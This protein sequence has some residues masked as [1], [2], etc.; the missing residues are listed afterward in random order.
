VRGSERAEEYV[1]LETTFTRDFESRREA[2]SRLA[3]AHRTG[4]GVEDAGAAF[5]A[6]QSAFRATRDRAAGLVKEITGDQTYTDANYVFPTFITTML[7]VGLTGLMIAAIFAAVMSSVSSE[8]NALSTA[9]VMD[10]YR[11]H[12]RTTDTTEHYLRVSK[13]TTGAWGVFACV[14]ATQAATIGT[15][16]E[17]VNRVGSFFYG[18]ILGVFVLAIGTRANSTGALWG[19]GLGMSTVA[20]VAFTT[21]VAYLWQNVIGTIVVVAVGTVVSAFTGGHRREPGT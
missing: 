3:E 11:R 8:L 1:A 4:A 2:A 21:N 16:I 20:A 19:L 6:S 9:T 10:F 12:F 17:V 18:S 5:L 7:P 13:L 14:I 15:L